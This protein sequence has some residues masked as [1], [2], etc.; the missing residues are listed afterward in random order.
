MESL[1]FNPK[2]RK[3]IEQVIKLNAAAEILGNRDK[4]KQALLNF[5]INAYQ[6]M[7]KSDNPVFTVETHDQ[8]PLVVLIIRDTGMGIKA[9]N[10]HR[11]LNRFT[12]RSRK[13]RALV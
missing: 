2:L 3:D 7:E 12:R 1:Q 4:L 5:I 6:A 9:E 8:G 13:V 11:I 10:L